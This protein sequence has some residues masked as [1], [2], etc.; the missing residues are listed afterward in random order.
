MRGS[1]S[2]VMRGINSGTQGKQGMGNTGGTR[3]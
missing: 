3:A 2:S 1:I